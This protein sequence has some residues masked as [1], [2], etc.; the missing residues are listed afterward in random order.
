MAWWVVAFPALFLAYANGANDNFK[1]VATLYG[2][3]TTTYSRALAWSTVATLLGCLAA[4]F[5][6]GGLLGTFSGK[7]LVPDAI[8]S[9][10]SFACSVVFAAALTV[11]LATKLGFPV[12]TTHALTGAL[13]GTG[14]AAAPHDTNLQKLGSAFLMPLLV[15]PVLSLILSCLLYALFHAARRGLRIEKESCVCVGRKVLGPVPAGYGMSEAVA[16]YSASVPELTTGKTVACVDRYRGEVAGVTAGGAIDSLHFL[17]AGAVCFAR[18]LN[19]TPKIAAILLASTALPVW[20]GISGILVF[21]VMG[22][23]LESRKVAETMA[24]KVTALNTGQGFSANLVTSLIVIFASKLGMPVS[25]T[26]VA[27]GSLFGIGTLTG[28][29]KWKTIASILTAW[30]TTLPVAALIG[31]LLFQLFGRYS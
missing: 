13:V 10:K 12:S 9:T 23:L 4:L 20:A 30:V 7:G 6:S 3:G 26:H 27:C 21:M 22:G 31:A 5:F 18:A 29:A 14:L 8:L 1:G 25:T 11:T 28:Q 15:S 19:D 17:S 24:H 2:S 16:L